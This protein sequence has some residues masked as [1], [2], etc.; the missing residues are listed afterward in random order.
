MAYQANRDG[1]QI[2]KNVDAERVHMAAKVLKKSPNPYVRAA[3]ITADVAHKVTGGRSSKFIA[4]KMPKD[5]SGG[6]DLGKKLRDAASLRG[7]Q[8]VPK[9]SNNSEDKQDDK[10]PAS[11]RSSNDSSKGSS[12]DSSIDN[13]KDKD[14]KDKK[15]DSLSKFKF[16]EIFGVEKFS[17]WTPDIN[18]IKQGSVGDCY[19]LAALQSLCQNINGRQAIQ[20]CFVNGETIESDNFVEIRLH[21]LKLTAQ[22][23]SNYL[24]AQP[25]QEI[26][27][28]MST[29]RLSELSYYNKGKIWVTFFERA[30][31]YYRNNLANVVL[32][33]D[34]KLSKKYNS[35][36]FTG[37]NQIIDWW[38]NKFSYKLALENVDSGYEFIALSA[39]TGK[40]SF[41]FV[42]GDTT[43]PK[44]LDNI[45]LKNKN[46]ALDFKAAQINKLKIKESGLY[47]SHAYSII[48]IA[49][50]MLPAAIQKL[51]DNTII[52]LK[53][54]HNVDYYLDFSNFKTF[55][56]IVNL[57]E[58]KYQKKCKHDCNKGTKN[59]KGEIRMPYCILKEILNVV[60]FGNN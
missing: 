26:I 41:A 2:D 12:N 19:L 30:F 10:S 52:T 46:I 29:K 50:S 14:K 25:Y 11:S 16:K 5:L 57:S 35:K 23:K 36:I 51:E 54:P 24:C 56:D 44:E 7:F 17:S 1:S 60:N 15:N 32:D 33:S 3:G 31:A 18:D 49:E 39:I 22:D 6:Q 13:K 55:D 27:V 43:T 45:L 59:K 34:L 40:E 8:S 58:S 20:S 48:A 38:Q 42:G 4:S 47:S 28:K 21:K 9:S 53:N 37:A